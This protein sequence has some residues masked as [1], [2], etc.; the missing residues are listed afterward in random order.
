M[1]CWTSRPGF[2]RWCDRLDLTWCRAP[3]WRRRSRFLTC[4]CTWC[5]AR[6]ATDCLPCG[7]CRGNGRPR[8]LTRS[9][10]GWRRLDEQSDDRRDGGVADCDGGEYRRDGNDRVGEERGAPRRDIR[11]V[12][13]GVHREHRDV[14]GSPSEVGRSSLVE[15]PEESF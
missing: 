9:R 15:L 4:T 8:S 6:W 2:R 14:G 10:G 13:T 3:G 1:R 11:A 5:P 12:G 7:R